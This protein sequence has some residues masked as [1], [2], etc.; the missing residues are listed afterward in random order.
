[1]KSGSATEV[2]RREEAGR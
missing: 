2:Q 1:V